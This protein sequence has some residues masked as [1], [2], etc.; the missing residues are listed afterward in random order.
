MQGGIALGRIQQQCAAF[1]SLEIS[2]HHIAQHAVG[3]ALQCNARIR[4][5]VH[6]A[7]VGLALLRR[8]QRQDGHIIRALTHAHHL[9]IVRSLVGIGKYDN[10]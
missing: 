7:R 3:L 5:I 9:H 2:R 6:H 1:T 4:A 8:A 10:V